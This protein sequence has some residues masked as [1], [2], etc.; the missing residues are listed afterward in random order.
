MRL[1]LISVLV[2]SLLSGCVSQPRTQEENADGVA[3]LGMIMM[4]GAAQQKGSAASA[5][6]QV[7]IPP[8]A[9]EVIANIQAQLRTSVSVRSVTS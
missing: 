4:A 7:R 9:I 5:L 1:F 6:W 2:M 3:V 8:S